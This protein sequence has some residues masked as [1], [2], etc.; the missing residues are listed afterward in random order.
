VNVVQAR[1]CQPLSNYP[2]VRTFYATSQG[3]RRLAPAAAAWSFPA[4][5]LLPAAPPLS[6]RRRRFLALPTCW[7][8]AAHMGTRG[9]C[10]GFVKVPW[11]RRQ[12]SGTEPISDLL[13]RRCHGQVPILDMRLTSSVCALLAALAGGRVSRFDVGP[14][15]GPFLWLAAAAGLS[16]R[17]LQAR[18]AVSRCSQLASD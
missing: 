11:L 15:P 10:T 7:C 1:L 17:A 2:A 12:Q 18:M 16:G 14:S 6:E 3:D 5:P 4:P 8:P 13:A 9:T